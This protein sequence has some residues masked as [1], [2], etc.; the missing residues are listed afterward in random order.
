MSL[1]K[2]SE[3]LI[4]KSYPSY[5]EN[6]GKCAK[7]VRE[8]IEFAFAPRVLIRAIAAKDYGL[9]LEKFGFQKLDITR[10]D[11]VNYITL[12]GDIAIIEYEP[13][14][15]ISAYCEGIYPA[16]GK[17][18]KCW[19]SDFQQRDLFGGKIRDKSPKFSI[20]RYGERKQAI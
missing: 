20:Y 13:Y 9:S 16:T 4:A 18:V 11:L 1:K 15:H 14:G 7:S 10:Q 6:C 12:V 8:A 17:K 19:V 5:N 2:L 3:F